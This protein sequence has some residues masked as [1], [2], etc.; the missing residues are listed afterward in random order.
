[1]VVAFPVAFSADLYL[2]EWSVEIL[3]GKTSADR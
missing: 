1:M 3:G 2:N